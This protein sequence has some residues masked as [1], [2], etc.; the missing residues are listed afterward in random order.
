MTELVVTAGHVTYPA[1][2]DGQG[3]TEVLVDGQWIVL[4]EADDNSNW[5]NEMR[6]ARAQTRAHEPWRRRHP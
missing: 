3:E 4:H 1:R 2:I 6:R 5:I